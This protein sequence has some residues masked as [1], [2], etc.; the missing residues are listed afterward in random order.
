M[1]LL[2]GFILYHGNTGESLKGFK[3]Q[4]P[5]ERALASDYFLKD[6]LGSSMGKRPEELWWVGEDRF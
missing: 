5:Q 1:E 4:A 6:P 3:P 2:K